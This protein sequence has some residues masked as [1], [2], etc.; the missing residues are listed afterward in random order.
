MNKLDE[1][2]AHKRTEVEKILPKAELLRAA[3]TERNEFRSLEA[4]L[5]AD[6]FRLGLIAEVKKASPSAGTIAE[7]FD[8]VRQA[9]MYDEGGASA[10][11]VLTDEKYFQGNLSYLTRIRQEVAI[12]VLRK[13]FIVDKVQIYEASVAGADAILL[14]AAALTDEEMKDLLDTAATFQL[15]VLLEVHD[16]EELDRALDT[17]ARLIGINNRNLKTFEVDLQTTE[18]LSEEIPDNGYTLVSESGIKTAGDARQLQSWGANALL[19]G[20][21]LMRAHDPGAMI[22]ELMVSEAS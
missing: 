14:I 6:E 18:R 4:A 7:D 5:N 20:E 2:I 15:E 8:P 12:P 10:I 17:D 21:T 9:K 11:S 13:D 1:I 16:R 3:A 19:V 22:G